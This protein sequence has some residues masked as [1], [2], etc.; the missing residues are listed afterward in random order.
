MKNIILLLSMTALALS[1]SGCFSAKTASMSGR[2]G[3]VVGV[4]GRAFTEPTP[5]GMVRIDRG[6]LKMGDV[7]S[8]SLWGKNIPVKDIPG[9]FLD[10]PDRDH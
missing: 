10:G 1:L 5:Y 9:R 4:G 7:K 3:E 2:G 8:D 6:Y